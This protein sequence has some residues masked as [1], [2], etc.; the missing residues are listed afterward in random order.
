MTTDPAFIFFLSLLIDGVLAGAIY[1]LIA[2]AFV[3][4]YKASRMINFAI[5]E[6]VMFGALLAGT[7]V[8]AM[9]LGL[10]GATL[11]ACVAMAALGLAFNAAVVAD[12]LPG[13]QLR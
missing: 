1:T 7:G 9:G 13:R 2:L 3:L 12:S 4:V 5:G 8:H 10:V 11:F 6:C